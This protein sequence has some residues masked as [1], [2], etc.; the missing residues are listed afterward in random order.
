M[1]EGFQSPQALDGIE[2]VGAQ[3]PVGVSPC[4]AAVPVPAVE[5]IGRRQSKQGEPE[6]NESGADV[7]YR[8]E[9]E[10]Q[11]RGQG[12]DNVFGL[13]AREPNSVIAQSLR[14]AAGESYTEVSPRTFLI[15]ATSGAISRPDVALPV[16]RTTS[17]AAAY[18]F[19]SDPFPRV[20]VISF[21][22]P[23]SWE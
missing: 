8:H 21:I 15:D 13:V 5:E 6:K 1:P 18:G 10:Y 16:L 22:R 14:F 12:S 20:T 19:T 17:E 9:G 3:N 2:K 23:T 11:E 7:D 4:H